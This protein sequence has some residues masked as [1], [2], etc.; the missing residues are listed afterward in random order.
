M[1]YFMATPSD[2]ETQGLTV[3]EAMSQ[4]IPVIGV[5]R[6]GVMD[7]IA[8]QKNGLLTPPGNSDAFAASMVTLL[9]EPDTYKKYALTA[10]KTVEMYSS[11]GYDLLLEKAIKTTCDLFAESK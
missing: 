7:Y 11:A 8:H 10:T 3:L 2:T 1:A 6:G 9:S 4:G 5:A